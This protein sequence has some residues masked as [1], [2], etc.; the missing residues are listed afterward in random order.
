MVAY[1]R[2][3]FFSGNSLNDAADDFFGRVAE[4]A[5]VSPVSDRFSELETSDSW[6]HTGW[7][8]NINSES[9]FKTLL[10]TAAEQEPEKVAN[11]A[12]KALDD[13]L[14][15]DGIQVINAAGDGPWQLMG[16]GYLDPTT[17]AIMQKAVRQS[18]DNINDPSILA[19]NLNFADY[20]DRVWRY[21]PRLT[22]DSGP[23]LKGLVLEYTDP[24][25]R[26]LSSAAAEII[27]NKVDQMISV[28]L[29]EGKL[30]RA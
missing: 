4:A 12:V 10:T 13:R 27:R 18:A 14:N 26:T 6:H 5:W 3:N 24:T 1:F 29:S 23:I 21:V 28:L 15:H 25:S 19:S 7:H 8:P 20:F 16:D 2:A 22:Q 17:L 11:F 30:R 9:R